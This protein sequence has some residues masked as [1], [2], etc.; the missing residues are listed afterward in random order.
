MPGTQSYY[1]KT[2]ESQNSSL[3]SNGGKRV[4]EEMYTQAT[5]E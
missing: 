2:P 1:D 5:I 3:L 4:P